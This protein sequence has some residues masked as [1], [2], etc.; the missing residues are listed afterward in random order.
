MDTSLK[1]A[2]L[3]SVLLAI[4]IHVV[5]SDCPPETDHY[6]ES[7]ESFVFHSPRWPRRYQADE[8]C[9]YHMGTH[10]GNRIYLEF[11]KFKV[12]FQPGCAY[13]HVEVFDG[14]FLTNTSL[15]LF[16]GHAIPP[17]FVSSEEDVLVQFI[18]DGAY[19]DKGFLAIAVSIPEPNNNTMNNDTQCEDTMISGEEGLFTSTGYPYK[20]SPNQQCKYNVASPQGTILQIN[21]KTFDI[22]PSTSCHFDYVAV[23]D[24][25]SSSDPLI[26]KYC[27]GHNNQPPSIIESSHNRL[28]IEL[29]SDES[30]ETS[31][32]LIFYATQA[33]GLSV[34]EDDLDDGCKDTKFSCL[35][36]RCIHL[37]LICDGVD[38]CEDNSD[39][40]CFQAV[41]LMSSGDAGLAVFIGC[42]VGAAVIVIVAIILI[43]CKFKK[44]NSGAGIHYPAL[45][46]IL[47][48]SRKEHGIALTYVT[49]RKITD[50]L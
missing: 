5:V 18:S 11:I 10:Q 20:Y 33:I 45:S 49:A 24:G 1:F 19:N 39:E 21:F 30:K 40:F 36:G 37:D 4:F 17:R 13:D 29:V 26:G 41:T 9:T 22:E 7:Y 25:N 43:Y 16:C 46:S 44:S 48:H 34:D 23:Y 8:H 47:S 15:G 2:L 12:E 6:L 31:G 38:D 32:F 50:N 42:F 35:N 14:A 27:N 28:H 3:I